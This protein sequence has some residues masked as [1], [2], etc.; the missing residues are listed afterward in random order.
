MTHWN[1][2]RSI[3]GLRP[4]DWHLVEFFSAK[5]GQDAAVVAALSAALREGHTCLSLPEFFDNEGL[6]FGARELQ[7]VPGLERLRS[8]LFQSEAVA[9]ADGSSS[10]QEG[11]PLV[12]DAKDRLYFRRYFDHELALSRALLRLAGR[13]E[14]PAASMAPL[15]TRYFPGADLLDRQRRAAELC[16]TGS[17]TLVSGGPGTGKT[18]TVVK[19]LAV[20][21]ERALERG[22]RPMVVLVAPTGKAAERLN[23]SVRGAIEQ[24][25]LPSTVRD[26]LP[27]RASTLHRALG[28]RPD[29]ATRYRHDSDNPLPGDVFVLD[30]ASMVDIALMRHFIDALRPGARLILLGDRHQLASVEAGAV[31]AE[32]VTASEALAEGNALR[33]GFHSVELT[34]SYRFSDQGGIGRLGRSIREGQEDVVVQLLQSDASADVGWSGAEA[35]R[36]EEIEQ[37]AVEGYRALFKARHPLEALEALGRFR[38]LCAVREG[39][40]GVEE[41]N[42]R[43][44]RA[45]RKALLVPSNRLH[46]PG[47][48][49]LILENDPRVG[50]YNGDVGV[51]WPGSDGRS[52]AYF[53][54]PG[55]GLRAYSLAE[56]PTHELAY[57]MTVHKSQ[58]SE[59]DEV[60]VVLPRAA[61]SVV[62]S[63]QL[64]YTGITRA[65][66]RVRLFATEEVVRASVR[67]SVARSSGLADRILEGST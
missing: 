47:R 57:A 60:V 63:R 42:D 49:V 20:L 8:R 26:C 22:Q 65:R 14:S 36:S 54:R 4:I 52:L 30:E 15:L 31:L 18:T 19:M 21:I 50:L 59:F 3:E 38:V 12:L 37:L 51:V 25:E 13:G 53:P 67:R 64:L 9:L 58:G 66:R 17:V 41:L 1:Y 7:V 16:M 39:S 23:E 35:V 44:G 11:R 33:W 32:L 10:I 45:L 6:R 62:L 40:C 61:D 2:L 46:Y 56:L 29:S 43:I 27:S 55:E 5:L 24:L 34:K 48:P 28:V